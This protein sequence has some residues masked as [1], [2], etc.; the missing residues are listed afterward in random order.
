MGYFDREGVEQLRHTLTH[1][2]E[3]RPESINPLSSE[4]L[5][6]PATGPFDFEKTLRLIMKKCA[7]AS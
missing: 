3:T 5:S 4:A 7:F 1:I 6:I 2:S